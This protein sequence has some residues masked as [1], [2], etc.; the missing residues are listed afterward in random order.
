VYLQQEEFLYGLDQASD[1]PRNSM[2]KKAFDQKVE[3]VDA[4]RS[5]DPAAA[6]APLRKALRDRSN[7]LVSKAAAVVA[8]LRLSDLIPDLIAAFER[9]RDDPAKSDPQCWAKT[10]IARTLKDLEHTEPEVFLRGISHVQ[11]E[12]VWGGRADSAATLRGTCALALVQ[13]KLPDIEILKHLADR[14]AD[15][16]KP[17]RVDAAL[18]IAQ[19]GRMEG[20]LLL[21]L[22]ASLPDPEPEVTGQCFASLLALDPAEA[23][24][25]VARFLESED[26]SVRLEAA[27][28]LAQ[29]REPGAIKILEAFWQK[30]LAIELR[31]AVL[32]SL[33]ASPLKEAAEFLLAIVERES[34]E[35]AA[36]ALTA[37]A[38]SRL[39]S[40][41]RAGVESAVQ[42]KQ[43]PAL[44]AVFDRHFLRDPDAPRDQSV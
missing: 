43:D 25:F 1:I 17:V 36:A 8:S 11:L 31:R 42:A 9:F 16:E 21:R 28:A 24:G 26:E 44:R 2:S 14:L 29:S 27:C 19:L 40:E 10:A 5:L 38:S 4:L 37:L 33:G 41:M 32:S 39:R 20:A 34:G 35:L 6:A 7:Y 23:V 15:P 18:A 12:P 3:A 30:R 13:C 22:K